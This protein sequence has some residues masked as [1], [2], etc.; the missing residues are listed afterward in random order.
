MI[1]MNLFCVLWPFRHIFMCNFLW[2]VI[3]SAPWKSLLESLLETICLDAAATSRPQEGRGPF[4]WV[5]RW[6]GAGEPPTGSPCQAPLLNLMSW[7][8]VIIKKGFMQHGILSSPR[9]AR[10]PAG[11]PRGTWAF[12]ELRR[13]PTR[14][15]RFNWGPENVHFGKVHFWDPNINVRIFTVQS[16]KN[17][18]KWPKPL[19]HFSEILYKDKS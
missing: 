16:S 5:V 10:A 1:L 6:G 11:R 7:K 8:I 14:P 4:V 18:E 15:L 3:L 13:Y 2:L 17:A 9:E 19:C 12:D